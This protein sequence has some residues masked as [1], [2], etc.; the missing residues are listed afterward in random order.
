MNPPKT[1][2]HKMLQSLSVLS[3]FDL[4]MFEVVCLG[5]LLPPQLDV[6]LL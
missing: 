3:L 5:D 6:V 4:E 1:M 2:V